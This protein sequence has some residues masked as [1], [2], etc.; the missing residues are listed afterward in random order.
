M[1]YP[2]NLVAGAPSD[3]Y[4][5][6]SVGNDPL[7]VLLKGQTYEVV[8]GA[9]SRARVD[10]PFYN[11]STIRD[12]VDSSLLGRAPVDIMIVKNP[13]G[14]YSGSYLTNNGDAIFIQATADTVTGVPLPD[15]IATMIQ[16][17]D[18]FAHV[19][20]HQLVLAQTVIRYYTG[21]LVNDLPTEDVCGEFPID[22]WKGEG[23][24]IPQNF[25]AVPPT[26]V[27]PA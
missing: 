16:Q 13:S 10:I 24:S 17:D 23:S 20:P 3:P 25:G 9:H 18:N 12:T 26:Y 5:A 8:L 14:S 22:Q 6:V 11:T 2:P 27:P 15:Q 21:P 1:A 7:F 19:P 4:D